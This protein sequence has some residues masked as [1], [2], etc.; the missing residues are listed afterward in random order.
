MTTT[1]TQSAWSLPAVRAGVGVTANTE[2]NTGTVPR[3]DCGSG[4]SAREIKWHGIT[5]T[6]Q[7]ESTP[8]GCP[9][10]VRASGTA[11]AGRSPRF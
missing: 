11:R 5:H 1:V 9:S 3:H 6:P 2:G 8:W 10:Q 4:R 7:T